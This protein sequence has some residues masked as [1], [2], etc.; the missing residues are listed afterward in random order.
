MEDFLGLLRHFSPDTGFVAKLS[1]MA[2][3]QVDMYH[4]TSPE[5]ARAIWH[6]KEFIPG[7][8]E[9]RVYGTNLPPATE[10]GQTGAE[11]G[12]AAVHLRVPRHLVNQWPG[13]P[14]EK[15]HYYDV[16]ADD[17]RPEHFVRTIGT[18]IQHE[19][20]A[21]GSVTDDLLGHFEASGAPGG[22]RMAPPEEYSKYVYPD[23]PKA[24]TPASLAKYF[25]KHEPDYYNQVSRHIGAHGVREPVLLRHTDPGG[26][27]L[28]RPIVM[29]GHH[30][31]A[32]AFEQGKPIPVGDYDNPEHHESGRDFAQAWWRDNQE[33][34]ERYTDPRSR[35]AATRPAEPNPDA[36]ETPPWMKRGVELNAEHWDGED[37]NKTHMTY[38]ERGWLPIEAVGRMRGLRGE[39]P[40]EHR[41]RQGQDWEDWKPGVGQEGIHS[42]IHIVV[43]HGQKPGI[44]EGNHR[45]DAAAESGHKRVPVE[46]TYFGNAQKQGTV[47]ERHLGMEPSTQ[48]SARE[49]EAARTRPDR[50]Q[51]SCG[52]CH[53]T[54]NHHDGSRCERCDGSGAVPR[55]TRDP[56][57]PDQPSPRRRHWR[58]PTVATVSEPGQHTAALEEVHCAHTAAAGHEELDPGGPVSWDEIGERYP[59]LYGDPAVHGSRAKD[60]SGEVIGWAAIHLADDRPDDPGAENSNSGSLSFHREVVDPKHIDYDRHGPD[61]YRVRQAREGYAHGAPHSVPPTIL[62]HR[63]GVY[64]VADG[65]HR[66]EGAH[67]AG[68]PV[69]AY[70]HYSEHEDEPFGSH[71]GEPPERGPFHGAEPHPGIE[72]HRQHEHTA[73]LEVTAMDD[74][75]G[76]PNPMTGHSDW[77]HG[78]QASREELS[79]GFQDPAANSSEAY[80]TPDAEPSGHWNALLGTH[81]A[82]SHQLAGAFA[83]GE[84]SSGANDRGMDAEP[85]VVHARLHLRNPK[86]YGSEHEIDD[87]LYEHEHRAG[88]RIGDHLTGDDEEDESLYP[89]AH[90]LHRQYGD[91]EIPRGVSSHIRGSFGIPS[92][93]PDRTVWVNSHPDRYSMAERFKQRLQAA[94]HD[95]IVYRNEYE[96]TGEDHP[97]ADTSAIAFH[98]R[99]IEMTGHHDAYEDDAPEPVRHI[100]HLEGAPCTHT[101]AAEP[102]PE[103]PSFTHR[104]TTTGPTG[105]VDK[106]RE[107]KGPF[108]HGGRANVG[109]GAMITP[110]RKPNPWGDEFDD[111]GRSIHTYFSTERETAASYARS[112]GSK[113]HL[114]EVEPTGEARMD[115]GGG[116]G[117]FKT[118][119]PLRVIRKL[120]REEWEQSHTAALAL[121]AAPAGPLGGA[122]EA[123]ASAGSWE[124]QDAGEAIGLLEDLPGF[125]RATGGSLDTLAG[126]LSD[127]PIDEGVIEAVGSMAGACGAAAEDADDI[128]A[129]FRRAMAAEGV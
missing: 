45:R 66:A 5:S 87:D 7:Q 47:W 30:R 10:K 3:D 115:G 77:Y 78:T 49:H 54:G 86:V 90:A 98:P 119:H 94:G 41:N 95:G 57:C 117:S 85:A 108:Y 61:D 127:A 80:E 12:T 34:K 32:A 35:T 102:E 65:H 17:I 113:G 55:G 96:K 128:V 22:I 118:R 39:R 43:D 31:A 19:A 23:Y 67:L 40:G 93:H 46:I 114:Y 4:H 64:Q 8:D 83:E 59:H 14:D 116:D 26:R 89:S 69:D 52:C 33:L 44:S 1:S 28:K 60:A 72:A 42:P 92:T 18:G 122:R 106:E 110:G 2:D 51:E 123:V 56:N 62:V 74:H 16:A 63:H 91:R 88:N 68:K 126:R 79:H 105:Y 29:G 84:H 107:V 11:Y 27:P 82:A 103:V 125:F 71:D 124:P 76:L 104:Y 81:F 109:P 99:Q 121:P 15:E 129:H 100:G 25:R 70:V 75:P 24:R 101:A 112:L 53:G 37:G 6:D 48:A 13:P 111:R 97:H 73:A 36:A 58:E 38:R 50:H 20:A 21:D 9:D 120:D